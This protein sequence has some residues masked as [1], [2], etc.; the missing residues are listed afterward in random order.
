MVFIEKHAVAPCYMDQIL[1]SVPKFTN[2]VKI[3]QNIRS[4]NGSVEGALC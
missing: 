2:I 3:P 4:S 1:Y